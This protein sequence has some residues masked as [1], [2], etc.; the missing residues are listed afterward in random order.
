MFSYKLSS[1]SFLLF[2]GVLACSKSDTASSETTPSVAPDPFSITPVTTPA[3]TSPEANI[4]DLAAAP[5]TPS[6][7]NSLVV[8]KDPNCGCCAKW[9]SYMGAQ[10]F[11]VTA[12]DTSDMNAVKQAAGVPT[13]AKSCHTAH[14]QGYVIEGHVPAEDVKRLLAE[15]PDLKGLAVAGMPLGS[16]GMEANMKQPYDVLALHKDG[17]TSVFAKH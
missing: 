4:A 14:I 5:N 17:S 8:Y 9:I 13:M 7:P 10:G 15:K 2:L 16:P 11:Q 1:L 12:K 6:G 3:P